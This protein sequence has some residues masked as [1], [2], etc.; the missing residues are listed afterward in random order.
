MW[1]SGNPPR[2][3]STVQCQPDLLVCKKQWIV[4][5]SATE[6]EYI[7][8]AA[9]DQKVD[10]I[11]HKIGRRKIQC[12]APEFLETDNQ[13]ARDILT[14][15]FSTK[16]RKCID[17]RHHYIQEKIDRQK[18]AVMQVPGTEQKSDVMENE[19]R[20]I[21]FINQWHAI[22]MENSMTPGVG[23][24]WQERVLQTN[25]THMCKS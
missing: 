25:L 16:Q 12:G 20:R 10:A 14:K 7:Y 11:P 8:I 2:I 22:G 23:W 1:S 15:S 17:L 3:L 9:T 13:S 6:T 4:E 19:L 18:L 5:M 24:Y 21:V